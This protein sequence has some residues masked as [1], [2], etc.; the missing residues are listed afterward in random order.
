MSAL[1][2]NRILFAAFTC[3]NNLV[4]LARKQQR[5]NVAGFHKRPYDRSYKWRKW[6][7]GAGV[8]GGGLFCLSLPIFR[9]EY[10]LLEGNK[11]HPEK[12]KVQ[13]GPYDIPISRKVDGPNKLGVKLTL[14]Q[15][16]SCPFCCKVR[17]FLD[18]RGI[19]Y[20]VVEVNP[21]FR[22]Q[23]K[24]SEYRKVPI[25]ILE[26]KPK[27][28]KQLNDSSAII[29]MLETY[30]M[31]PQQKFDRV[32]EKYPSVASADSRKEKKEIMNRYHVMFGERLP[33]DGSFDRIREEVKW[34]KWV[35]EVLVHSLS[36]NI[37]RTPGESYQTFLHFSRVGDWER[38][39]NPVER[40]LIVL[41]GSAAMYLVGKRL[42]SKYGLKDDVR[43]SLYEQIHTWTRAVGANRFRGGR[44]PDLSDL[45]VFGVLNSIEGCRAFDD[46][47]RRADLRR[48]YSDTAEA[49]RGHAGCRS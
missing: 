30:L 1:F 18:Y 14:F 24:F 40:R 16:Q 34:R 39:F 8:F 10:Q 38:Y 19:P 44:R 47:M 37:Y 20:D 23:L 36:P 26:E 31:D 28:Y 32:A 43:Q 48:W 17:A 35:D 15:Y 3:R 25:V 21:V 13:W 33:P 45:A 5:I 12:D 29:S 46:L 22:T 4:S 2:G 11:E 7:L 49:V 6:K 42:K 41:V 9:D 27:Q